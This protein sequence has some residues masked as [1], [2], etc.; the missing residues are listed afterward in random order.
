M[1]P[2][3]HT[4]QTPAGPTLG[5]TDFVDPHWID[6]A[7]SHINPLLSVQRVKAR[8]VAMTHETPDLLRVEL[9]PNRLFAGFVPG[10][11]VPLRVTIGGIVHE[12]YYSLTSSPKARTLQL[13]IK[14]QPGGVVS[15]YV[16][17][18]LRVGDV[19]ELGAAAGDFVLPREVPPQLLLIAGGSGITPMISLLDA[20]LR[21]RNVQRVTLLYYARSVLDFA[22]HQH[23]RALAERDSRFRLLAIP[24]RD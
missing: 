22:F 18:R 9:R 15:G 19:V 14:K 1:L 10:Q 21:C 17:E 2:H 20:A 5:L 16:H 12:R 7:L 24:E 23:L 11:A 4:P 8:V 13:G 3:S 6:F